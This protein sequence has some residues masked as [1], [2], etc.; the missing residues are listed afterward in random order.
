MEDTTSN[1][2]TTGVDLLV[3]SILLSVIVGMLSVIS[4]YSASLSAE[5][6]EVEALR[7][8]REFNQYDSKVVYAQDVIS[9]ILRYRGEPVVSVMDGATKTWNLASAPCEY[10][11]AAIA[12][13]FSQTKQYNAVLVRNA[14]NQVVR[15]EFTA[16]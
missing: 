3:V 4:T 8:Y 9:A 13:Q 16:R 7:E 12:E 14:S 10:T 5:E 15:I 2:I 1:L 11:T 6:A